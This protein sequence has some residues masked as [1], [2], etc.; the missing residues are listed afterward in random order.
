M[1]SALMKRFVENEH[2]NYDD[3]VED[4]R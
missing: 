4:E 1:L 3:I 2:F